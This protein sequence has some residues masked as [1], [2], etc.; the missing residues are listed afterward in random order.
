L[1]VPGFLPE[2]FVQ[3]LT[4]STRMQYSRFLGVTLLIISQ[5]L[6]VFPARAAIFSDVPD[7]H[8]YQMQ[9]E[10][11]VSLKVIT[12]NP[13][14]TFKP[15]KAVNRA[16]LLAMLYR[17]TSRTPDVAKRGCFGDVQPGSWYELYVCDAAFRGF[18]AGYPDKSFKPNQSV[19]RVEALKMI[20]LMFGLEVPEV[21]QDLWAA[22]P[23]KD[24]R[25]D[26]WYSKYLL[27]A[28]KMSIVPID[29]MS[30]SM[31]MPQAALKKGEAAA[32]IYSALNMNSRQLDTSVSSSSVAAMTSSAATRS[33]RPAETGGETVTMKALVI[34]STNTGNFKKKA[35]AVYKFTLSSSM[36]IHAQVKLGGSFTDDSVTCRLYKIESDGFSNEYYLGFQETGTCELKTKLAAGDYQLELQPSEN[37]AVYTLTVKTITGDGNDGFSEARVLLWGQPRSDTLEVGDMADWYRFELN[38]EK[39]MMLEITNETEYLCVVYPMADVDIYG[40]TGPK[41]GESYL[42]PK[43]TYYVGIVRKPNHKDRVTYSIRTK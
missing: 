6:I 40:F 14:G 18:V 3:A 31:F 37:D 11:L 9:I 2:V 35:P 38:Q 10:A 24:I 22:L 20:T 34:P 8:L 39:Q 43:G 21:Q 41:C 1:S 16:E 5:L 12:G 4:P 42:F 25:S 15:E 33:S 17:A 23:F 30:T 36:M 27:R 19:N 7:G 29:G 26:Q 32:L 13:D 28:Y